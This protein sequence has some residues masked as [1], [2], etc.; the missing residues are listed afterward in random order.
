MRLTFEI[1]IWLYY[2]DSINGKRYLNACGKEG[3]LERGNGER[4]RRSGSE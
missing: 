3:G 1:G 4:W 2:T